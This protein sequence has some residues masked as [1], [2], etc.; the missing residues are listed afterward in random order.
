V[1]SRRDLRHTQVS[2]CPL[3]SHTCRK[4]VNECNGDV[5]PNVARNAC[6]TNLKELGLFQAARTASGI[7]VDNSL[8]SEQTVPL[9]TGEC[10]LLSRQP[11]RRQAEFWGAAQQSIDNLGN[12][13]VRLLLAAS[14]LDGIAQTSRCVRKTQKG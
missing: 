8:A 5:T 2:E 4:R 6:F 10:A 14:Y 7:Y 1:V 12:P 13:Q 9:S 11:G 3:C